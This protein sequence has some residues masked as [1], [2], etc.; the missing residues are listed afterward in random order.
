MRGFGRLHVALYRRTGGR[1]GSRTKGVPVLLLTTTGRRSRQLRTVP[2]VHY[3]DGDAIVISA[4]NGGNW[5]PSWFLN[6]EADPRVTVQLGD[7]RF[8]AVADIAGEDE[9]PALWDGMVAQNEEFAD[10]AVRAG[11]LIPMVRLRRTTP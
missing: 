1:R 9:R 10:Y 8:D 6:L 5:L 4:S 2:L 7:E 11:R 3:R